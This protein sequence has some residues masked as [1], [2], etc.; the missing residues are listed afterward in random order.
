MGGAYLVSGRKG[1][2]Q[3]LRTGLVGICLELATHYIFKRGAH[4]SREWDGPA[5]TEEGAVQC[6]CCARINTTFVSY[7]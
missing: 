4:F 2:F 5:F 1:V 3:Q 7:C 6:D